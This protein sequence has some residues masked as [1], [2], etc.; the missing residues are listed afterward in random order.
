MSWWKE[1]VTTYRRNAD[2]ED[3][4]DDYSRDD[5]EF[6]DELSIWIKI[7]KT[8]VSSL[9]FTMPNSILFWNLKQ[10][11]IFCFNSFI[12]KTTGVYFKGS[13]KSEKIMIS[14]KKGQIVMC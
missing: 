3:D 9:P 8:F 2:N 4:D 12:Q 1:S 6:Y 13:L 10:S 7:H 14:N 5:D 11:S